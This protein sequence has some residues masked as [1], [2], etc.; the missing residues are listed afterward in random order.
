MLGMVPGLKKQGGQKKQ[1]IDDICS[2]ATTSETAFS[3]PNGRIPKALSKTSLSP[4]LATAKFGGVQFMISLT[5]LSEWD[6]TGSIQAI[7]T[8]HDSRGR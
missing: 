1:R 6:S 7:R 5:L 3:L 4:W 2:W 8:V